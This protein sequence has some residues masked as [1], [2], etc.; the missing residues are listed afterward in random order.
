MGG[1]Q[2]NAPTQAYDK[3]K[4]YFMVQFSLKP[5]RYAVLAAALVAA[6]GCASTE[7]VRRAQTTA[8]QALAAANAANQKADAAMAAANAASSKADAAMSAANAAGQKADAVSA[9]VDELND[10]VDKMFAKGL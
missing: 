9:R 3:K 8:D 1:R 4:E 2:P 10:K 7:D 5:A 6:A